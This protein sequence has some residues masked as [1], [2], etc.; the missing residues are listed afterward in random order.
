[1]A[2][3]KASGPVAVEAEWVPTAHFDFPKNM[4][5][6]KNFA[7]LQPDV[8]VTVTVKGKIKSFRIDSDS[9][10]F[11]MTYDKVK[12]VLADEKPM[13]VGDAMAESKRRV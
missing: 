4:K 12:V 1:M 2:K 7:D 5:A 13:G 3:K 10:A 8:E 9:K 6:P 11:S